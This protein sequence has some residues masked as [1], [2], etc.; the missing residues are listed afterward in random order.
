MRQGAV[1]CLRELGWDV[2]VVMP[3]YHTNEYIHTAEY[4]QIPW[5]FPKRVALLFEMAGIF[6]DYLDSWV[7]KAYNYLCDKVHKE[8]IL[9]ATSGGELG[10]VKLAVFLKESVAAACIVNLRDPIDY[11]LV[12]GRRINKRFHVS[13]EASEKT[14]LQKADLIITSSKYFESALKKKY[15]RIE[16]KIINNYFGYVHQVNLNSYK[17][18]KRDKLHIAYVGNMEVAQRPEILIEAY[19]KVSNRNQIELFFIGDYQNYTPLSA[20]HTEG[21]HFM[22]YLPHSQFLQFMVEQ[23]DVGFVSLADD[24]YAACFPSKIYEYINLGLPILG[25][26]PDGDAKDIIEQNC[27]G[28]VVRYDEVDLLAN[29]IEQMT[30]REL[31]MKYRKSVLQDRENWSMKHQIK[32]I[33]AILKNIKNTNE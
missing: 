28:A 14:Y 19:Q 21:V 16:E 24:Y 26:L 17:I 32:E 23:I 18:Q 30:N 12:N 20:L 25:A 27:Y 6:E 31:Y 1:S 9:F 7:R 33:D 22:D 5:H 29:K 4:I 11:T 2:V 15:P 10:T 3:N 8:D 13:R